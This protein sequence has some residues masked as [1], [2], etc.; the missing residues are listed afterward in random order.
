M[1]IEHITCGTT[2]VISD[3]KGYANVG[4]IAVWTIEHNCPKTPVGELR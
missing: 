1:L 4:A 2:E 3:D